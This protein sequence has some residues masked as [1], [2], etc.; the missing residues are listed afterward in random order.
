MAMLGGLRGGHVNSTLLDGD[1][2]AGKAAIYAG[3][4]A[5]WWQ[6]LHPAVSLPGHDVLRWS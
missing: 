6:G 4:N 5:A 3:G 1:I 2:R